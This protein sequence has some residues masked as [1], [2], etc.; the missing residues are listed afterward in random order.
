[1]AA[2]NTFSDKTGQIAL[3]LLDENFEY[4]DSSLTTLQSDINTVQ[5]NLDN[6][7]LT[8]IQGNT[9]ITGTLNVTSSITGSI[10]ATNLVGAITIESNGAINYG[11]TAL[12]ASTADV[13][14]ATSTNVDHIWHDDAPSALGNGGT[15]HFCSDTT[16]RAT[17][18]STLRAASIDTDYISSTSMQV[19]STVYTGKTTYAFATA[20]Q[21]GTYIAV[22]DTTITP[23]KTSSKVRVEFNLT[24]ECH[25]DTVFRLWRVINGATTEVVRNSDTNYWSGFAVNP[26]DANNSSTSDTNHYVYIDSPNTTSAVTYRLMIQSA[27]VGANTLYLNR[28]VA[29]VGQANY[30]NG[31]SQ[32]ILTEI[33]V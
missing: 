33:P 27:G 16:Y 4:V 5:S 26:Y 14:A 21:V 18:N 6:I 29:A 31:V 32:C 13:D 15:W 2:P 3:T 28:T 8:D 1:M 30:E 25:Q 23:T 24:F 10:N 7:D 9:T 17:G 22:L 12:I 19:V 11:N 20:G